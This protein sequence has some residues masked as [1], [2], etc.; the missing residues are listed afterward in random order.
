MQVT[1]GRGVSCFI[2]A[3][4]LVG[5][6]GSAS[7]ETLVVPTRGWLIYSANHSSAELSLPI[8]DKL[9][10]VVYVLRLDPLTDVGRHVITFSL[11]LQRSSDSPDA[12]NLLDP[13]GRTHGYQRWDFAASDLANGAKN[14]IYG[15]SRT[16][17][18]EK[19]GLD[20][21]ANITNAVVIPIK[22][23]QGAEFKSQ[24]RELRL[25][26]RIKNSE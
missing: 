20:V 9:G 7:A 14:S 25:Q 6:W 19:L 12:P 8:K 22:E 26:V 10:A 23:A 5:S 3:L 24:F 16:M 1:L 2:V 15:I 21:Q 4:L 17:H 11:E 13:T 18:L